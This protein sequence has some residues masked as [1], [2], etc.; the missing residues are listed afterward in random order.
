MDRIEK[1]SMAVNFIEE[2]LTKKLDLGEVAKQIHYSKN[3]LHQLF[4]AIIGLTIHDYIKRRQL[5]EAAKLLV[6]SDRP[7][8]E[9][10]RASCRERV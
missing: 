1:V 8:I 5:T 4:T 3:Q 6:F 9:I 2:N 10:G 7:I